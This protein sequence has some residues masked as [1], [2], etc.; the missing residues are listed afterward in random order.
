[1]LNLKK[2]TKIINNTLVKITA[3]NGRYEF[4]NG[5]KVIHS[6][7]I[8]CTN[9]DRLVAHWDSLIVNLSPYCERAL[10]AIEAATHAHQWGR[11]AAR[12]FAQKRGVSPRLYRIALQ[13][14]A[15]KTL[16]V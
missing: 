4:M 9:K 16:E 3:S 5:G 12:K 8:I 1:M 6:L 10:I 7:A 15:T 11:D 2:Y 13:C 14:E